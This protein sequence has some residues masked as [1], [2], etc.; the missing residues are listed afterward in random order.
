V[1][2]RSKVGGRRDSLKERQKAEKRKRGR[3]KDR[4]EGRKRGK[5]E[6]REKT[7]TERR[8]ERAGPAA[9]AA[10][11]PKFRGRAEGKT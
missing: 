4:P 6:S 9:E 1:T 3:K 11:S 10:G 7:N 5:R 2:L 8:K